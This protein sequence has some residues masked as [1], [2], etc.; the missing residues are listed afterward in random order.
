MVGLLMAFSFVNWFSRVCLTVADI[1]IMRE[2]QLSSTQIGVI[3]SALLLAYTICMT[4][5]GWFIERHGPRLALMVMGFGTALSMMLT[6]AVFLGPVVLSSVAALALFVFVRSSMG[7]FSAPIYPASGKLVANWL[8]LVRRAW[9][10]GLINGAAPLG[11]AAAHLLFG[12]FIDRQGWRMG[13]ISVGAWTLLLALLWSRLSSDHPPGRSI[14]AEVE[15]PSAA[16]STSPWWTLLR[17]RSL[18]LLTL[19]YAAVGYFEYLFVFC[20]EYY[21]KAD[22]HLSIPDSRWYSSLGQI[23]MGVTMALGGLSTD[24]L[25]RR[26][27]YRFGRA[28]VP[29]A[30]MFTSAVS[31]WAATLTRDPVWTLVWFILAQAAIGGVEGSCWSTAIEL[32]GRRGGLS[33]GIFNTGGNLGGALAPVVTRGFG[34]LF[35]SWVPGFYLGSGV[36]FAGLLLWFWIDPGE[37]VDD[38]G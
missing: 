35:G 21:F 16:R 17:N 3:D 14:G 5:G 26:L 37:R 15:H 36:C 34:D 1:P 23:A 20:T 38:G 25:V 8:P 28:A 33:A 24:F 31:L 4:P 18:V 22:L 7:V 6:G 32:G 11:M 2:F 12:P 13:F 10:N 29:M 30:C 9:A 19:S 27:G